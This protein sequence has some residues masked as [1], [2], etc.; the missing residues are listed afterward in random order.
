MP[1]TKRKT[2]FKECKSTL[3]E[4]LQSWSDSSS[5]A[6]MDEGNPINVPSNFK[7]YTTEDRTIKLQ[8]PQRVK[9][10]Q[11]GESYDSPEDAKRVYLANQGE[12]P[13]PVYIAIDLLLEEEERLLANTRIFL[14]GAI[15]ISRG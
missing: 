3:S 9:P 5:S 12:E 14:H 8:T 11:Q 1:E 13:R 2:A 15:K 6:S 10:Q 7:R 4:S